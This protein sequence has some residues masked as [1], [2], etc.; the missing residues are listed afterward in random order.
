M[1]NCDAVI[2]DLRHNGGGEPSMIRLL[3]GY[4]FAESTHLISWYERVNDK[5]V[6]SYSADFVPGRRLVDQ[7]VYILTSERTASAAEEFTFDLKNHGRATIVGDTTGG[8]GHTVSRYYFDFDEF[9]IRLSVPYGRAHNPENDEGWEGVGV[10]PDIAVSATQALDTAHADAL[11]T[12]R[13]DEEDEMFRDGYEWMLQGVD[14]RLDP[15]ELTSEQMAEYVGSY[16]PRQVFID[17]GALYYQ[18]GE[19]ASHRLEPMAEDLFA[20]GD[21]DYFRI[22]FGR[23]DEGKIA[24]IIGLRLGQ[25]SD[26]H[27]RDGD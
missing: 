22:T 21:Y 1:A 5:T 27:E 26:E 11:R 15:P 6:Q 3:A 18:R 23:N 19:Q 16:G 12:L 24:K 4:L 20:V 25:D 14:A 2:I 8:A 17:N 7:P 9:R 13:D 10:I